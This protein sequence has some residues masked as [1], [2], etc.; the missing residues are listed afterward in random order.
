MCTSS[1][2]FSSGI[3][4]DIITIKEGLL[5]RLLLLHNSDD[6]GDDDCE[7]CYPG[8]SDDKRMNSLLCGRSS[9]MTLKRK[10][11]EEE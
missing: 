5:L 9:Q 7:D 11:T 10:N 1:L 8:R 6:D 4:M 2:P 3:T